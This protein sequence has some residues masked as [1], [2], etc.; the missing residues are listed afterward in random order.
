MRALVQ[1]VWPRFSFRVSF[2]LISYSG[3]MAVTPGECNASQLF[4]LVQ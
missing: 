2:Y 4:T 1:S 3:S